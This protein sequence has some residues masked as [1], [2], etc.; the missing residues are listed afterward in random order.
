MRNNF[1]RK[2]IAFIGFLI[3]LEIIIL[4]FNNYDYNIKKFIIER[5]KQE[6]IDNEEEEEEEDSST[7]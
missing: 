1:L 6:V 3:Y 2:V 5:S 7:N 4:N